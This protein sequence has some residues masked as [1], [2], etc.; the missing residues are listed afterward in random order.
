MGLFLL[1]SDEFV[2]LAM[3]IDDFNL[4]IVLEVLAQL[5]DVDIHRTGIEIV[6]VDP[7][8]L[9]SKVALQNLVG[10]RA[11]QSQQFVLLGGELTL[12]VANHQQ[13]LLG[14]EGKLT[15]MIER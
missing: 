4:W 2:S 9:Q 5:G 3:D 14:I 8:G 1:G 12:L 15:D 13:L 7:D 10:M 11:E 6:V